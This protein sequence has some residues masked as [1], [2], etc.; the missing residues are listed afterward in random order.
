MGDKIFKAYNY[1]IESNDLERL[2]KILARYE[3]FKLS[4]DIPGDIIECGVFKGTGHIFWLKLLN[5]FDPNSLKK[6]IGFDTFGNFPKTTLNF[7]KKSA[8]KFQKESKFISKNLFNIINQ[9]IKKAGLD[10]RS[11]LV[12]GDIVQSSKKYIKNNRGF[13]ISLLHLDL[14]TYEGTKHA[15]NNFFPCISPGGIIIFDEYGSRGWGESE[16][17]DE[18]LKKTK[19]KIQKVKFSSKPTAFL[20]KK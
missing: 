15:L 16:A 20:I 19:N 17:V 18:F 13:R 11:T 5:I 6:V 7:E 14:D 9:K 3:L 10:R 4:E 1:L 8:K 2:K 12:K